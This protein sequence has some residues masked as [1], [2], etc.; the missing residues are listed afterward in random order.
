MKVAKRYLI[1]IHRSL[2]GI[3]FVKV[4]EAEDL[5]CPEFIKR[6]QFDRFQQKIVFSTILSNK[7]ILIVD[8][9]A[10]A[11]IIDISSSKIVLERDFQGTGDCSVI[12]TEDRQSLYLAYTQ[13]ENDQKVILQLKMVNLDIFDQISLPEAAVFNPFWKLSSDLFYVYFQSGGDL[14][15]RVAD[16]LYKVDMSNKTIHSSVFNE[17]SNTFE[18]QP[19]IAISEKYKIGARLD[20]SKIEIRATS[21]RKK[22]LAKIQIF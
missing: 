18:S 16:G 22:Y 12:I 7:K 21:G 9:L 11:R 3:E 6:I 20:Y 17:Q 8:R 2:S 19:L 4:W 1:S 15:D 13:G 5:A 14:N 10:K